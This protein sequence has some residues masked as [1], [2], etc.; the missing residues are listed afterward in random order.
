MRQNYFPKV[1]IKGRVRV[2]LETLTS[3]NLKGK[4]ILDIGSS[5][6]WLEKEILEYKPKKLVGIEPDAEA[7]K[8]SQKNIKGAYFY[9]ASAE[10]IPLADSS[11]D[12]AVM[13]DVIEHVPKGEEEKT[14]R[15]SGRVLKK[16]GKLVLSTPNSTFATNILD[17]AWYFGHRHYSREKL[18]AL[19]EKTGFK[20]DKF[21]IRGGLWFSINLIWHYLM[22]WV[23]KKPLAVNKF[24]TKKDDEQFSQKRGIHTIFLVATKL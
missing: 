7:V 4:S 8:Y 21:E 18:K 16:G 6:G 22:K 12:I 20:I 15:E 3:L 1:D 17:A 5:I 14:L 24:L 23:F 19:L 11:V 2:C 13:F 9:K 10:R